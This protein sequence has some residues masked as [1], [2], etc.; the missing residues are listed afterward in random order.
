M[1]FDGFCPQLS[2]Q[3]TN[4]KIVN[5]VAPAMPKVQNVDTLP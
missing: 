2:G 4:P 1:R 3:I 5:L